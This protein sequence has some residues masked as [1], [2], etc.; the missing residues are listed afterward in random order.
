MT[1][2]F[3]GKAA[4]E[5]Y[6]CAYVR[7]MLRGGFLHTTSRRDEGYIAYKLPG[8]KLGLKTVWPVAQGRCCAIPA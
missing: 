7:G 3:S 1:A 8:E 5:E 2:A 4:T 6:I